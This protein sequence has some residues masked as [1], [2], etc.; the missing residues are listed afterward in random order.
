M[1]MDI[2]SS[3]S[4]LYIHLVS[5]GT[6]VI[7][8]F[9]YEEKVNNNTITMLMCAIVGNPLPS[10]TSVK[11]YNSNNTAVNRRES[12]LVR[13]FYMIESTYPVRVVEPG[14]NFTC[15]LTLLDG[16]TI[17]QRFLVD[18]YCKYFV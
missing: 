14:E 18:V 16:S 8:S 9:S 4:F 3:F 6:P 15:V 2:K 11:V 1:D 13:R 5:D 17:Q 12:R 10:T 7:K